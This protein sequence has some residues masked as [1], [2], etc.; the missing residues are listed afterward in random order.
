MFVEFVLSEAVL[1]CCAGNGCAT[2]FHDYEPREMVGGIVTNL[3]HT[4]GIPNLHGSTEAVGK[5]QRRRN[6]GRAI[7]DFF[8][9][10]SREKTRLVRHSIHRG[11]EPN[12]ILF[13]GRNMGISR[14]T[15]WKLQ[16]TGNTD[17][18]K[19]QGT[20]CRHFSASSDE[21][22]VGAHQIR[23]RGLWQQEPTQPTFRSV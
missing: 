1:N 17:P 9:H 19:D 2:C 8:V 14:T 10:R 7:G 21:A 16:R 22:T 13:H 5:N 20:T 4:P 23:C 15:S 3:H 12:A 18:Q 6:R 11:K